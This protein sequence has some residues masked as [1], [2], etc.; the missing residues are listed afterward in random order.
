MTEQPSTAQWQNPSSIYRGAPF[1][2]WNSDLTPERLCRQIEQMHQA[3]M[4]GFFMH[5]RYGL[6]TP[7][8]SQRWFECVSA[9]IEKARELGMKAYLY[10]EDR[11]P[12]GAAGGLVTRPHPELGMRVLDIRRGP[13]PPSTDS[14][15]KRHPISQT[16][17]QDLGVFEIQA[18]A[19]GAV[20]SYRRLSSAA[21]ATN[22]ANLLAFSVR[23]TVPAGW[24]NDGMYLDTMNPAAVA[25]FI[26][27]TH[28][29]YAKRY[30]GDFGGLVPAIFTDEPFCGR[31]VVRDQG[32]QEQLNWTPR[33]PEEFKR[34]RGYDLLPRLPELVCNLAAGEFAKVRHDFRLTLLEL[35][36]EA[37]S[38]PY[39][40]WCREHNI[41]FTGHYLS[42][43][44]L[45]S[46]TDCLAATM[47]HYEHQQ[48][49]GIDILCDRADEIETAKQ[50]ASVADQLGRPR[51]L[52]EL[53]GCTGWDWPLEGHKFIGDWQYALGVNFRCQHLYWYTAAGGAKRDYPASICD[54]SPWWPYYR[55]VED[56]FGRLSYMLTQGLPV[57]DVLVVHPIASAWGLFTGNRPG[58]HPLLHQLQNELHTLTTTLLGQH[59]DWDFADESLLAKHGRLRKGGVALGKMTYKLVVVPP[60][61]TLRKSTVRMLRRLVER[62]G[63]LLFV[64]R[65]PDHVDGEPS[66]DVAAIA[67]QATAC[68]CT[69]AAIAATLENMLT[70]RV[71]L[72][73]DGQ[74][75]QADYAWTMLRKIAGGQMLFVQSHDRKSPHHVGARV[76]GRGP[77]VLWDALTGQRRRLKSSRGTDGAVQFELDLPA[78][79]S[80]LVTLG[81]RVPDATAA[82]AP[83]RVVASA[84]DGGPWAITLTEPN[85]LPLDYCR[86]QWADE[87]LSEPVPTLRADAEIR[88]RCGLGK[89]L[90]GEHQPWYLYAMGT[91][92]TKPRARCRIVREFHITDM[93]PKCAL[94][95]E[96]PGRFNITV[97]GRGVSAVSGS[98]LDEDIK[99]LD[100]TAMLRPGDNDVTLSFDYQPDME[101][102]DVYLVGDFGVRLRNGQ[103]TR[104][105]G[106][107]TLVAQPTQLRAGSW[108][109]QGL[110]F[111]TGA[112]KYHLTAI[113]PAGR[114]RLR[115][116]LDGVA[117]TAAALHVNG[118]TFAMPWAP[119]EA[120]V[121]DAL[122]EGHNEIDVEVI[123]GRKNTMGPLHVPWEA[124]T[125]PGQ[126]DP[127]HGK[128]QLDYLLVDHGLTKAVVLETLSG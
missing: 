69:P 71:S 17:E 109:G 3:G 49:P 38:E 127:D 31:S 53:Y 25:E 124:W 77:V 7:Y 26:R 22:P 70:R 72:V 113:K 32:R 60:S 83:P 97:N 98:W 80:A 36:V 8:L 45:G 90:G 105:P 86:F 37:F 19:N 84:R 42:E 63:K 123:G 21:E 101:I 92:D 6:K 13:A 4:G 64:G 103:A 48:W 102:E 68:D 85:T 107:M 112:V 47:P 24:Y 41:A 73:E 100:I 121:T 111:Y 50:C 125:G 35:F 117:C 23:P 74:S 10:D 18:D 34:R 89:R 75:A 2:A 120:D 40:R 5:S 27:V 88:K 91:V 43:Q 87:P 122:H 9:C 46:Q 104:K 106:A 39:G 94:A 114:R 11:W 44:T 81:V 62:G 20:T 28:D 115:V 56:Y 128:W 52:S 30:S 15:D 116:R 66:G 78:T 58:Q 108:I 33:L 29:E 54:H 55:N 16:V 93:P 67:P 79:G 96:Q 59:Y 12:S 82:K 119:F 1:W 65:K 95:I 14:W 126:F 76:A 99:T 118:K 110:D 51:V 57:R 61:V